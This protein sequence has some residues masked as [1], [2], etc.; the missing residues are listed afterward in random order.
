MEK[1]ILEEDIKDIATSL[2]EIYADLSGKTILITGGLG[3]LGYYFINVFT[4]LNKHHLSSPCKLIVADNAITGNEK[5]LDKSITFIKQDICKPFHVD[6]QLDYIIHAASI[7]SP[8][9]YQ[10]YPLETFEACTVGTKHLLELAKTHAAK[11]IFFSSSEIYGDPDPAHVPTLESYNGNVSTLGSRSCYDIGK[12]GGETL[13]Y[14]YSDS[15][16]VQTS[17][18]RPFNIYGPGMLQKDYR[19]I[20]NFASNILNNIPIKV[21]G[22]GEQTRTFCYI[23]DAMVG[24]I[25]VMFNGVSHQA[26]NIGNPTPEISMKNLVK[27]F[28]KVLGKDIEFNLIEHPSTYP[29]DEPNRR[30][31]DIKKAQLQLGYEPKV[32]LE[33]GLKKFFS[34]AKEHYQYQ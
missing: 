6:Q 24:F 33:S 23:S 12:R 16:G 30:C 29:K 9:Y 5:K 25:K 1:L 2:A 20:P 21:Y 14:I 11:F 4:Y 15:Y 32:T 3:F 7:A 19:V 8:F 26:Y 27:T 22:D 17:I 18:I 31:P 34:W 28:S 13:C 10:K